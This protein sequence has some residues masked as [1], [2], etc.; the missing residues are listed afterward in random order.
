MIQYTAYLSKDKVYY[1]DELG[2]HE[3]SEKGNGFYPVPMET[4]EEPPVKSHPIPP[5]MSDSSTFWTRRRRKLILPFKLKQVRIITRDD[6]PNDLIDHIDL[7]SDAAVHVEKEK[8][9]ICWHAVTS[10]NRRLSFNIPI[11]VSSHSYSYRHELIGIYEGLSEMTSRRRRVKRISCHCDNEAGIDQIKRP[12]YSPSAT[13]SSDMDVIL[14]IKQI[15]EN[16]P[17]IQITFQH[18]NGHADKDKPKHKCTRIEQINIDCDTE[19]EECVN[20][21][22]VPSPYNPL[23]GARCMVKIAGTWISNRVDKAMQM[24]P[25]TI[26]QEK[27]LVTRLRIQ[28][29]SIKDIDDEVIAAA[30][31]DHSWARLART[32]KMMNYWMPV[33]HNWRHHGADNDRCPCC[34]T[35]DET[36]HHLFQCPHERIR[37]LCTNSLKYI[38]QAGSALKIPASIIWLALRIIQN[39]CAIA[40]HPPPTDP[41]LSKVWEAQ[42]K[43]GFPN[44]MLGWFSRSWRKAIQHYGSA[45]PSGQASQ[46]VTLIWDGL[47]EPLWTCRNDIRTNTPNPKDL[48]EMQNLRQKLEWY[49]KFKEEVLPHRLR[50]LAEYSDDDIK[51]W[52]RDRRK[53]V[54]RMLDKSRR[55]YEIENKQR[56]K[57]QR[58]MTEFFRTSIQE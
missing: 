26:A 16:H 20:S 52:D 50:F 15:V 51:R 48:L 18:V 8:G 40:D 57:G 43:L 29:S 5:N 37:Q 12:I 46:L 53:T 41:V 49:K 39:E 6:L 2:L 54:V 25:S 13:T 33:G 34:G 11:E 22:I 58:V 28:E 19:A 17:E 27:Y 38:E 45:D 47:C 7:V 23:P 56:M 21:G 1:R 3:C 36:F 44:F 10:D 30:R 55:I 35:P 4:V 42:A 24:I 32:S 14:A 9:A 31:S